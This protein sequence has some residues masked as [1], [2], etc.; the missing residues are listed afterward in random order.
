MTKT[1]PLF[2]QQSKAT[3]FL[4]CA[5]MLPSIEYDP[6]QRKRSLNIQTSYTHKYIYIHIEIYMLR[7]L[8]SAK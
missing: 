1:N 4:K 5:V 7:P 6:F 8:R 2:L 3:F